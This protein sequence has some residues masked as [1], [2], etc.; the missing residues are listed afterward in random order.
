MIVADE[1]TGNL[2]SRTAHE[3]FETLS[4]LRQH[5]KTIIYVTHA[6]ALAAQASAR[7][8][9]LDGRIGAV[10]RTSSGMLTVA[11]PSDEDGVKGEKQ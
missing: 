2:D 9:L 8:D 7:I 4:G 3:I 5:G 6:P 1:P 11:E 10:E